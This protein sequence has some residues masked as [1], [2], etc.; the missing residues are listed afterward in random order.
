MR[1]RLFVVLVAVLVT[2]LAVA[3]T[4]GSLSGAKR[5]TTLNG[6]EECDTAGTCKLGDPDGSGFAA[7][8]LNAG[9]ETVCWSV[10]WQDIAPPVA[11]HIHKGAAGSAGGIVVPL[12]D[13]VTNAFVASG[14]RSASSPL[15]ADIIENSADYYV[16]LHNSA[17]P[18]GAIRGQLSNRGQFD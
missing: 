4:A 10:S 1:L 2:A 9:Q 18:G 13:P 6:A 15:I 12:H 14:C 16:N 11:G 17:F 3:S 5:T 7:I 8:T